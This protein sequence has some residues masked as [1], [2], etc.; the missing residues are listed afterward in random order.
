MCGKDRLLFKKLK[1]RTCVNFSFPSF[2]KKISGFR[3][4]I[5]ITPVFPSG[6]Q[7]MA[8]ENYLTLNCP[9][10]RKISPSLDTALA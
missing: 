1:I 7:L 9:F 3:L 6:A 4:N 8:R 10:Y 2:S 5:E